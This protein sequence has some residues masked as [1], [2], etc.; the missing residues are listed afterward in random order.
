MCEC[1]CPH[2]AFK[3]EDLKIT[4]GS[5]NVILSFRHHTSN[6][7]KATNGEKLNCVKILYCL[8]AALAISDGLEISSPSCSNTSRR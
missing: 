5:M 8:T 3:T 1:A 7:K 2:P 4:F 6:L